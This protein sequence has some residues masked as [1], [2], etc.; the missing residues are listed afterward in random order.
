MASHPRRQH[1]SFTVIILLLTLHVNYLTLGSL[2]IHSNVTCRS[3]EYNLGATIRTISEK[4]TKLF[5]LQFIY[6]LLFILLSSSYCSVYSRC[7]ATIVRRSVI[8]DSFLGNS[9]INMFP[10][11][12]SRKQRGKRYVV[13][14]VRAQEL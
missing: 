14:A 5:V 7:Y 12:R 4:N 8:S 1:F 13:Y 3:K 9:S 6:F 2:L 10:W 11:Q